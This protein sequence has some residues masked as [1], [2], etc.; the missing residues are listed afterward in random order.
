MIIG[1]WGNIISAIDNKRADYMCCDIDPR[2]VNEVRKNIPSL[3]HSVS[4]EL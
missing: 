2:E 3:S 4:L 1:P